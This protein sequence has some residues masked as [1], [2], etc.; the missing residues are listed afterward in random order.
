V[1]DW[2]V[3][4]DSGCLSV[5]YRSLHPSN[6]REDAKTDCQGGSAVTLHVG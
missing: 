2:L 4:F 3:A 5:A 6:S 1:A